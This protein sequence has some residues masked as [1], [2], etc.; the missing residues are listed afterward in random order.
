MQ[1][2]RSG[3][4]LHITSLPSP[5]GIGDFGPSAYRFADFLAASEQNV[6]QML[7]LGPTSTFCGNSPYCSYSAFAGNP[8]MI[9]PDLLVASGYLDATDV[10]DRPNFPEE[11]VNFEDVSRYKYQLLQRACARFKNRKYSDLEFTK[12]CRENAYWLD[13]YALFISLKENFQD[14][15][16]IDWPGELRDSDKS[17]I[18]EWQEK[19]GHEVL[20]AKFIQFLFAKQWSDLKRYC[21][22]KNIQIMG[23]IPIYVS[24]DSA[25]VWANPEIFKL[26]EHKQPVFVAGVPPDYFSWSGQLWGNPVYNWD[27]L[28]ENR[29][30]W[31]IK[32]VE[33]N[34]EL[35][36]MVRLD[37]FRGFVSY[38]E[39]PAEETTAINGKW[40]EAP[41]RE[42]FNSLL[43]RFPSLPIIAEDLGTITPDVREIM[44][45][46]G[47]AGMKLLLFAFGD[48]LASN[49][50]VPHNH[51]QN[52]V[53]YTGTHD[54][55]TVKGWFRKEARGEDRERLFKYLG[56]TVEE[57]SVHWEFIRLA[58]MSVAHTTI[59]PVQDLLGLDEEARMNFPSE[60]IGNWEWRLRQELL[61]SEVS[62]QLCELTMTYGR[63]S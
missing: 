9:S 32:R 42:F 57:D 2:R 25:D 26:N 54:N 56:R 33:R 44:M 3:L 55:N 1:T 63:T 48:D 24:L 17:A 13:N 35:F 11:R 8:L 60:A 47:F 52:C 59:I 28:K 14:G 10:L 18:T 61:T 5:Y 15:S 38:W 31:W 7:P 51:I 46:Y 62:E 43:R 49:P 19:L 21:N 6:W 20:S 34:F 40:I 39:V 12:F 4:L 37:H 22:D 45:I 30:H 16:W 27:E 23:D 53:V 41:T 58:M 29:Y 50:Y 36:D